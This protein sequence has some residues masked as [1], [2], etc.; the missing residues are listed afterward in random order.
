[1]IATLFGSRQTGMFALCIEQ[2]G[3]TVEGK[4]M[5]PP[6]YAQFQVQGATGSADAPVAEAVSPRARSSRVTLIVDATVVVRKFR[7]L[8][9]KALFAEDIIVG[10][11]VLCVSDGS[12]LCDSGGCRRRAVKRNA[13]KAPGVPIGN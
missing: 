12:R 10:A 7:R 13:S 5:F 2:G 4:A 8:K 11:L 3:A 1:V 9:P 6:V